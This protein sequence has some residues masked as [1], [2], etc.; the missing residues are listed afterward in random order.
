MQ[1]TLVRHAAHVLL[2]GG[3]IAYPTEGVYGLG[4]LPDYRESVQHILNLKGRSVSAGLI[5]IAADSE[6]LQDWIAPTAAE[7]KRLEKK[8]S[9][10]VTWLVTAREHT[11]GWLTGGH[12]TL[13]V[14]ITRHPVAAALCRAADSPL[15]STSANRSGRPPA[16]TALQ[17]R[18]WLGNELD[19]VVAGPLGDASGPSEIR[20]AQDNRVIRAA[21]A[22]QPR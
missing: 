19:A 9:Q 17:A 7:R 6:Q 16:R 4:C 15:V 1:S 11:P 3:V 18:R 12:N 21:A 8:S 14:R 22:A 2:Q 5:L 20:M 10:P 13:A